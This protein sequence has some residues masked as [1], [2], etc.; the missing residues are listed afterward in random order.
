MSSS[1]VLVSCENVELKQ[2][3]KKEIIQKEENMKKN[4][5]NDTSS[6]DVEEYPTKQ[7][8]EI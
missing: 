3:V 2:N 7:K 8:K 6:E 1:D 5:E 4:V